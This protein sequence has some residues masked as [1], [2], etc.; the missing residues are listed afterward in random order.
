MPTLVL[1]M[2]RDGGRGGACLP[3][4][5][6]SD[7]AAV[8]EHVP[9]EHRDASLR[10]THRAHRHWEWTAQQREQLPLRSRHYRGAPPSGATI[11][12]IRTWRGGASGVWTDRNGAVHH[13]CNLCRA[14][15][16]SGA[17]RA[18]MKA[19]QGVELITS[20]NCVSWIAICAMSRRTA[21]PW[22]KSCTK[23]KCRHERLL[24]IRRRPRRL[25]RGGL[26]IRVTVPVCTRTAISR[27][28][29]ASRTSSLAAAK[30]SLRSK[31]RAH[32]CGTLRCSKSR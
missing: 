16:F 21:R 26:F 7:A 11:N 12:G 8:Y 30:T 18:T 2:D 5:R 13:I 29:T 28:A 32:Y 23:R 24:P 15:V 9:R 3:A 20:V 22:A 6:A 17:E 4:C 31:S 10:R 14:V 25:L 27:S 1:C 19:G